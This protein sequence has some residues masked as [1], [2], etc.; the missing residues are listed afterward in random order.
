M[1]IPNAAF[2]TSN[3]Y[4]T[5]DVLSKSHLNNSIT[6]EQ[7]QKVL[8]FTLGDGMHFTKG[9][10]KATNGTVRNL[11]GTVTEVDQLGTS[12][13]TRNTKGK[14]S[15]TD[16]QRNRTLTVLGRLVS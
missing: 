5:G 15:I 10:K 12:I 11:A 3:T 16:T 6:I 1:A 14:I 13:N 2:K 9:S 7:P 8:M 4:R